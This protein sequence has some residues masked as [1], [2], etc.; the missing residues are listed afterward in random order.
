MNWNNS[1]WIGL[2]LALTLVFTAAIRIRLLAVPLERDE[3]EYAYAGQLILQG[4]PPYQLAYNMKLPGI[5]AFYA[6]ILALFGQTHQAIHLGLLLV[7]AGTILLVFFLAKR[8]ISSFAAVFAA[9]AYALLSLL[10]QVQG[11]TANAEPFVLLFALSGILL[12]LRGIDSAKYFFYCIACGAF[13]LGMGFVVKQHGA[14]FLGFAGLALAVHLIRQK[15]FPVHKTVFAAAAFGAGAVLPFAMTCL[16]LHAAGVFRTFW[17]WTF[18]Y[19]REYVAM[20]PWETGWFALKL[21]T[22]D[23][24]SHSIALSGLAIL[25][26][27]TLWFQRHVKRWTLAAFTLLSFAAVSIGLYYRGHYFL[28]LL[29]AAA[30]LAG[31][32]FEFLCRRIF[33]PLRLGGRSALPGILAA[34]I[35]SATLLPQFGYFFTATPNQIARS[36]Y[37]SNPFPESLEI[38][39]FIRNH[40]SPE[41]R[42]A[43]IGSEPQIYFYS[44]RRSATGYIYTYPLM[45][46]HPFTIQM[47][48]EM[49]RQIE[50][51]RPKFLVFV[52]VPPSWLVR[53]N[54]SRLL[55]SWFLE[56]APANYALVGAIDILA[57][58][59]TQYYWN[60]KDPHVRFQ[61][62]DW[63]EI[64]QRKDTVPAPSAP[65]LK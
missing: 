57:G 54:S 34:G 12:I 60:P 51:N 2:L 45:E 24:F 47:Q 25:G 40:S 52:N 5:Y 49:I 50:E 42:I 16:A 36:C 35:F 27:L 56:Y 3:G 38:A 22:A 61:S 41:D 62:S 44:G 4:V 63:I 14:V 48:R 37:G 59:Q 30:M 18:E 11:F 7:N 15:P 29:P 64:F 55:A 19:A 58:G 28:F 33:P 32:A 1:K 10:P 39:E 26:V 20:V 17:F 9:A 65:G 13:L 8:L 21:R 23:I 53:P 46:E 6:V 43:V 31:A